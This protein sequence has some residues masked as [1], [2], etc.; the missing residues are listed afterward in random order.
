MKILVTG[1]RGNLG[2]HCVDR[3]EKHGIEV[4]PIERSSWGIVEQLIQGCDA[5]LHAAGDIRTSFT[6][7]PE[8]YLQSNVL[9]SSI[10]LRLCAK[11][12]IKKFYF[13][14]SCA[15]Y[16]DVNR[17]VEG[18]HC[19]PI[20]VN[21]KLKKLNEDIIQGFCESNGIN[22]S[23]FRVFNLFGGDDR[24]SIV[25]YLKKA[26]NGESV[27]YLNNDGLSLRDFIHVGD[28]S[29]IILDIITKGEFPPVINVGTGK[30]VKI[31]D[32]LDVVLMRHPNLN[33]LRTFNEEAEYSRADIT[34]LS[35]IVGYKKF[36]S[37]MDFVETI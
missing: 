37:I 12:G 34:Q 15:V 36:I 30:A 9:M 25:N 13:V 17:S 27:F 21:G 29:D 8:A 24:F 26:I 11:Y 35:S 2:S 7:N 5:V 4:V 28:V 10:L 1:A 19:Y 32:I 16:G 20:S 18:Q 6:A 23:S 14:S 3:A 33:I 22:Y 31:G